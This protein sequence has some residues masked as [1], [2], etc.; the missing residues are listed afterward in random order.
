MIKAK[1]WIYTVIVGLLPFLIRSLIVLFD[2]KGSVDYWI[3]ETDF[4]SLGLVLNLSNINE[5]ENREL[6]NKV[7]KTMKIGFSMVSILLFSAI[8]AIITY[9]DFKN[10]LDIDK[11]TVKFCSVC[12]SLVSV[13]FSYS[14][15][16][17]LNSLES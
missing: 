13:L 8:F 12:L 7:W 11:T 16:N 5:L 2:K 14:I 17:R 4:I 1:W 9:S 3:N 6:E 10:N 15:Y